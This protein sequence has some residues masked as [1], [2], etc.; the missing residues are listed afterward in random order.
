MD[1]RYTGKA[2]SAL[3]AGALVIAAG[4]GPGTLGEPPATAPAT[5]PAGIDALAKALKARLPKTWQLHAVRR[6]RAQPVHWP[7]GTGDT[8]VC[9]RRGYTPEDRKR[10]KGGAVNLYVMDAAYAPAK[11]LHQPGPREAQVGPAREIARWRRRR[12][13]IFGEGGQDW[14]NWMTD[15][16]LA[17][18]AAAADAAATRPAGRIDT[19][20]TGAY[21]AGRWTYQLSARDSPRPSRRGHLLRDKVRQRPCG[22][23]A[24]SGIGRHLDTPWGRMYYYGEWRHPWGIQ[25]WHLMGPLAKARRPARLRRR[26]AYGARN[27]LV[28]H[29]KSFQLHLRYHGPAD[30]PYYS[31]TLR[32]P[33]IKDKRLRF[34]PAAQ[35][36]QDDARM[37]LAH[38]AAEGFLAFAVD[39][40]GRPQPKPKG[41]TYTL[42][43]Q[44]ER[45]NNRWLVL[46]EDIGWDLEMLTRLDGLRRSLK[47]DAAKA[48]DPL[49]GRLAGHRKAWRAAATQPATAPAAKTAPARPVK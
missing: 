47:G 8:I 11:P 1:T 14:R 23:I 44:C 24:G 22:S 20:K 27:E 40:S 7:A 31:L 30:K 17:M 35:I 42:T 46:R 15:V 33:V 5:R 48:M 37:I 16:S 34:W 4:L 25:G 6:G 2:L 36:S 9:R 29:L 41:P 26:E 19:D 28:K 43:V 13:F 38:L 12:V 45:D 18:L 32:V 49:L 3:L 39:V 21:K 10:H